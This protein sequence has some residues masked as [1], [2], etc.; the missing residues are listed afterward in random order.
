MQEEENSTISL[1]SSEHSSFIEET[2]FP[3]EVVVLT[4]AAEKFG[5]K[6]PSWTSSAHSASA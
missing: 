3:P 1:P 2:V 4:V 6:M 5:E